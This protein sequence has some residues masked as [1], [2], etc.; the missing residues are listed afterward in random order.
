MRKQHI[1]HQ[2]YGSILRLIVHQASFMNNNFKPPENY[3]VLTAYNNQSHE[4]ENE[5]K[6]IFMSKLSQR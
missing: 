1:S 6:I 4:V 3:K 5:R 2:F